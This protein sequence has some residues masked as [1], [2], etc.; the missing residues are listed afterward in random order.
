[1]QVLQC[2]YNLPAVQ[3]NLLLFKA[4]PL[5]QVCEELTSIHIVC[6]LGYRKQNCNWLM[7]V[8]YFKCTWYCAVT[9]KSCFHADTDS[10]GSKQYHK[11]QEFLQWYTGFSISL[12]QQINR[13]D[14]QGLYAVFTAVCG[15]SVYLKCPAAHQTTLQM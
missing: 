2:Q 4:N 11:S 9:A 1:M 13:Y 12:L 7:R 5:D 15:S 8:L 14:S 6:D 3:G 10:I